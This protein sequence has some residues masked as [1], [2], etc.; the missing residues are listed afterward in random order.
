MNLNKN[1]NVDSRL[2]SKP[3]D[4]WPEIV[5]KTLGFIVLGAIVLSPVIIGVTNHF[6]LT[7]ANFWEMTVVFW[8]LIV[9]IGLRT[10]IEEGVYQANVKTDP[11]RARV[12]LDAY[13]SVTQRQ[14]AGVTRLSP[15]PLNK[16]GEDA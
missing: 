8:G 13:N 10:A 5:G 15:V 16:D 6:G 14:K 1:T 3:K 11:F 7:S 2:E 4:G 9:W 12:T